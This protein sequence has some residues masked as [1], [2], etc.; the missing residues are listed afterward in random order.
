MAGDEGTYWAQAAATE[1]LNDKMVDLVICR[2]EII[3][4]REVCTERAAG[5]E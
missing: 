3:V 5:C 4:G 1:R 2:E